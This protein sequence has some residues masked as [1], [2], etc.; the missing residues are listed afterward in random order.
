MFVIVLDY[1]AALNQISAICYTVIRKKNACEEEKREA[2]AFL[3]VVIV[4]ILCF[5]L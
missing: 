1:Y 2:R 4:S 3:R 5:S